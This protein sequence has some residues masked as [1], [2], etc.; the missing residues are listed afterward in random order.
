MGKWSLKTW[1]SSCSVSALTVML[2]AGNEPSS[3]G[4]QSH[5]EVLGGWQKSCK[6]DKFPSPCHTEPSGVVVVIII[7]K[8]ALVTV[9]AAQLT[10]FYW[11]FAQTLFDKGSAQVWRCEDE[12]ETRSWASGSL[13]RSI[14][15]ARTPAG[16]SHLSWQDIHLSL[17]NT[18]T[19]QIYFVVILQPVKTIQHNLIFPP[20]SQPAFK[21]I[22]V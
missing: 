12:L 22:F 3:W 1:P 21:E 9:Q 7:R 4:R 2:L 15:E 20:L 16:T 10:F 5:E 14:W 17:S 13:S 19:L 11:V 6:S 18:L 8:C